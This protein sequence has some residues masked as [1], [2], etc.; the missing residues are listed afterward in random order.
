ML[1]KVIVIEIRNV[2]TVCLLADFSN[3]KIYICNIE[4]YYITYYSYNA[5]MT[6][7]A[8]VCEML[9]TPNECDNDISPNV[10]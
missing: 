3:V 2:S 1:F 10:I 4:I 6:S 7:Y 5:G 9:I 8:Y